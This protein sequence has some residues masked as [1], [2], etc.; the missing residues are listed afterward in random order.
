MNLLKLISANKYLLFGVLLLFFLAFYGALTLF[1]TDHVEGEKKSILYTVGRKSFELSITERGV[2]VPARI[3]PISSHIS[4]NQA[5]IVWLIK[6][7]AQVV[8]GTLVAR[9][10]TK[11]FM[12][13]LQKSEQLYADALATLAA[14]EKLL[15]LQKDEENGKIE[16]ALRKVEIAKIQADNIKHGSGPLK[17]KIFEQKL[18]QAERKLEI[19][20]DELKDLEM[21]LKK[22][23]VSGR[24]RDKIADKLVTTK[25]QLLVARAELE[26][27]N[28]YA[29][30]KLLREAELLV[31]GAESNIKRVKRTAELLVQN[32]GAEVIKNRRKVENKKRDLDKSKSD[33]ANCD[34]YSPTRG[35]LLYSELP[36]ENGKRKNQIGDSVWEGQ[37]FLQVPDTSELVAEIK[38][39]EID[40][41]KIEDEMQTEIELDA[42]PD[43]MFPGVVES[44]ASLAKEDEKQL[45]VRRFH[46]RIK[47]TGD[48]KSVHVGMSATARIVYAQLDNVLTVPIS[49]VIYDG[50]QT[51]VRKKVGQKDEEIVVSL[52]ARGAVWVEVLGGL[53]DMDV[54][55]SEGR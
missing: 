43:M 34:I 5:K 21:L 10:D 46:T 54:I 28:S 14:S 15:S 26:N 49:A 33:V 4:S 39:R 45:G 36:R 47:F 53:S 50:Q 32:R 42:F 17:R 51:M 30:P 27:F 20:R 31:N 41:A 40:V 16:E 48:T 29:W 38:V 25:E 13:R 23:H 11:P 2:V 44:V 9:F 52:G 55:Y 37:P 1:T 35:I 18:H 6:E 3:S 22:G 8:K 19:D 12:D 7:G 24:E